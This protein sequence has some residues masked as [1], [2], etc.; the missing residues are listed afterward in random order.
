[1]SLE[2][3]KIA[4]NKRVETRKKLLKL[5]KKQSSGYSIITGFIFIYLVQIRVNFE[6]GKDSD[7][8]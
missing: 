6:G 1:M 8:L 7:C 5:L 3:K 4:M 2:H